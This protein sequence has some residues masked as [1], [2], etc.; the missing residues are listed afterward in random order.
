MEYL[1][2]FIIKEENA[3]SDVVTTT[4]PQNPTPKLNVLVIDSDDKDWTLLFENSV[5]QSG[6]SIHVTKCRWESMIVR[7]ERNRAIVYIKPNEKPMRPEEGR[8]RQ[9][10]PD[11]VIVRKLVRG[12]NKNDDYT[13]A[14]FGLMFAGIPA[15]NSLES[16]V[17]CLERP[18]V[19]A[20]LNQLRK[21]HGQKFPFIDQTYF[22]HATPQA[23]LFTPS[24]PV[25]VKVGYAEAGYGKMK[26]ENAGD[27]NDFKGVLA[28]HSDYVTVE[29]FIDNR[30]YDLRIQKIGNKFRAY[31]RINHNWK[32][33]VGTSFV[34]EIPMTEEFQ[35]WADEAGQLFGGMDIL[36]VD[37]IHTKDGKD[38]ILEINDTASGL[39]G[40]NE[41]EDMEYIRDLCLQK[42]NTLQ[43]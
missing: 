12:L 40:K 15:I 30:E 38:Y 42:I 23:M 8:E 26:F 32:G 41:I 22:S 2:K 17:M 39:F 35:F 28:L 20:A 31:K 25:V 5:T 27:F 3:I 4:A 10:S 36:T 37:A 21:K 7:A 33:N 1:K 13:N 24:L 34:E 19:N 16:I 29:S 11:F 14:L 9:C 18:V 6:K 43:L